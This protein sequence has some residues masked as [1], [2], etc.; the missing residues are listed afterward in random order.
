MHSNIYLVFRALLQFEEQ[1]GAVVVRN[2]S[3]QEISRFPTKKFQSGTCGGSTA[4]VRLFYWMVHTCTDVHRCRRW[5]L[6]LH[7][8]TDRCNICL[9]D[10]VNGETLR[11]L[12]CLHSYHRDCIDHWLKVRF[13]KWLQTWW[14]TEAQYNVALFISQ[15]F[16]QFTKPHLSALINRLNV[17][18]EISVLCF[19]GQ[20]NMPS[21]QNRPDWQRNPRHPTQLTASLSQQSLGEK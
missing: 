17:K 3:P 18:S 7:W 19:A 15:T 6:L 14:Q 16:I 8:L 21:L 12:P 13:T 10:Y 5:R 9:C 1:Q 11:T 2:L 4:W 20:P